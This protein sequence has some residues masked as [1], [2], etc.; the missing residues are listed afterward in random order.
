[1]SVKSRFDQRDEIIK[2]GRDPNYFIRTYV[3]IKHPVRGLIPFKMFDYQEELVNSYRDA[4]VGGSGSRFNVVL[5]ARQ[6]G[7]SEVTAAY[8]LWL[9]LFHREKNV[10][11]MASKADTAK[12]IL[13]KIITAVKKIPKWLMLAEITTENKLSIE[14]DNGSRAVAIATSEDA[15]RS[16]A[17]SFLIIDEA[18]F[19]PNLEELWTGLY[20]TVA[21]GGSC[22]IIS[23]PNGVGNK[24]HSIYADAVDGVN[25]FAHHRFMWWVHPE[26]IAGLMDDPDR[27]GFKTCPWFVNEV[28]AANMSPRDVAQELECNFNASGDTVISPLMLKWISDSCIDPLEK[29]LPDRSL[30]IWNSPKKEGR[31]FVTA[32]VARGDGRD[33]SACIVW[34]ID[35]MSQQA[36]YYGKIPVGGFAEILVTLGREYNDA[37]L[38]VENATV[39]LA[40]L[41]HIKSYGYPNVYYSR[42]GDQKPGE[43]VNSTWGTNDSE[44]VLGFTT[45]SK[46]RP[47]MISKL[48]EFV[49]KRTIGIRSRR[50][51]QELKTFIW[52][53]GRPEAQRGSNDDLVMTA[54]IAVWIRDTF[55]STVAASSEM[56]EKLLGNIGISR[57]LNN[58]IEGASK[59]P[60]DVSNRPMGIYT[61]DPNYTIRLPHG[62]KV[63][64]G[65]LKG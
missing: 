7:I 44:L 62:R 25:D 42:R 58:E 8:A 35:S 30:F 49:R 60:R 43:A 11:V 57:V 18:A 23:T 46:V 29:N 17:V 59:D 45:S 28:K 22:A 27:P 36:E 4:S 16:E 47:L 26:R 38:V 12:N 5:K 2:C 3:K 15:G 9:M 32:D 6:L 1:M 40:C 34:D 50:L 39:G 37:L 20:P 64:L 63:D 33:H 41:E 54:A 10:V 31:Y 53:D 51:Y 21:A 61:P 13:R 56:T 52:Q 24:F 19:V 55:L 65:W 14:F 48:E